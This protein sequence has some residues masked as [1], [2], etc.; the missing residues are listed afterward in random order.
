MG[1]YVCNTYDISGIFKVLFY[2]NNWEYYAFVE[3]TG[4]IM[5][6]YYIYILRYFTVMYHTNIG[7]MNGHLIPSWYFNIAIEHGQFMDDLPIKHD[8]V[9]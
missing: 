2:D 5:G 4:I 3:M 1:Q 7:D 8:D 6:F 9:P